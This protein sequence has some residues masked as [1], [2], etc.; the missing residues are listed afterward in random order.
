MV[1][2]GLLPDWWIQVFEQQ[3]S[4]G[5]V[6][7]HRRTSGR[8]ADPCFVLTNDALQ[9]ITRSGAPSALGPKNANLRASTDAGR[10]AME[11]AKQ[12]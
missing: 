2:T 11:T 10:V 5:T 7:W 4:V 1:G 3:G 12:L 8:G 6:C 9:A